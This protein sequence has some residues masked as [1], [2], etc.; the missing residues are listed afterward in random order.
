MS[1]IAWRRASEALRLAAVSATLGL[2]ALA[3]TSIPRQ[4]GD[5]ETEPEPKAQPNAPATPG[6]NDEPDAGEPIVAACEDGCAIEN[7]KRCKPGA[8]G[9]FES[10]LR[11][12]NGCLAWMRL[13]VRPRRGVRSELESTP[14]DGT[15]DRFRE[16]G[17]RS[18]R[19]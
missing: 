14:F 12:A 1:A 4:E 7:E 17:S 18:R 9:S 11:A 19:R 16:R 10:C 3:C 2:V 13:H 5:L 15:C 6:T 8:P